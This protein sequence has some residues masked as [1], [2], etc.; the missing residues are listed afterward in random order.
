MWPNCHKNVLHN[1]EAVFV[2][3]GET[4]FFPVSLFLVMDSQDERNQFE[5][6]SNLS[7][8]SQEWKGYGTS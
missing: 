4:F 8:L 6:D 5:A 7:Y 1:D 3:C 2:L